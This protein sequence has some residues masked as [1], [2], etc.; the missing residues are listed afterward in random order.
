MARPNTYP[1]P[2]IR[3]A[4]ARAGAAKAWSTDNLIK[5]LSDRE[6]TL[7]QRDALRGL[8]E[9]DEPNRDAPL[10]PK[11]AAEISRLFGGGA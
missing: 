5:K 7:Q 2:E 4:R 9:Q 8:I 6:L 11:K 1:P 10:S 3:Q